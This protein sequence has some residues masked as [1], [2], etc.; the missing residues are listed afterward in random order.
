MSTEETARPASVYALLACLLIQ[1]LSGVTG[2]LA[3]VA[4]PSGE[5]IGL[6]VSWLRGSPLESYLVPGLILF[7]A[8]GILPLIVMYTVW[9]RL[10]W[11]WFASAIVG[12]VL[13]VW[14]L[15]EILIIG[16][17]SEPPL[18]LIYGSLGVAIFVLA[19]LPSVE[20]YCVQEEPSIVDPRR[21]SPPS[22]S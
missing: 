1:G 4:D 18:Q 6:P 14:I 3:L 20:A 11:A 15:V 21:S 8:L 16:Y 9:T 22:A 10:P 2:G 5:I 7:L 12:L 19:L 17:Q 13:I